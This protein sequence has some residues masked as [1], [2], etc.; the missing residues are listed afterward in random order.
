[1]VESIEIML[2]GFGKHSIL[3]SFALVQLSSIY[4]ICIHFY[5]FY[6]RECNPV[7]YPD[8]KPFEFLG[9]TNSLTEVMMGSAGLAVVFKF[10]SII[11]L[12]LAL[13][14]YQSLNNNTSYFILN[15][16]LS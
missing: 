7:T 2:D 5:Q 15:Q 9:F 11:T 3:I 14:E 12:I 8:T 16:S 6:L 10:G 1:M 13:D 4:T